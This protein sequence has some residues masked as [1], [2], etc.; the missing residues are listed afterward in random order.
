MVHV[1]VHRQAHVFIS[2]QLPYKLISAKGI[3]ASLQEAQVNTASSCLDCR[4]CFHTT[5]NEAKPLFLSYRTSVSYFPYS[6]FS[7]R[8]LPMLILQLLWPVEDLM[9]YY[10]GFFHL[11]PPGLSVSPS[12]ITALVQPLYP[13]ILHLHQELQPGTTPAFLKHTFSSFSLVL[14]EEARLKWKRTPD[15][16]TGYFYLPL[17]L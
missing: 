2:V 7:R 4:V 9:Q 3:E 17:L 12:S 5:Q 1:K 10:Q 6:V 11:V 13:T 16:C 15:G 8:N 14:T